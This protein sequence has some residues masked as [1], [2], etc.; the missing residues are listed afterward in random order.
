MANVLTRRLD[1]T[2]EI[3]PWGL[4]V[5]LLEL[6]S[7]LAS[8][9]WSIAVEGGDAIARGPALLVAPRRLVAPTEPLVLAAAVLR[10]TGRPLRVLG[11][12]DIAPIGPVLRRLGGAVDHPVEARGLLRAG[13]LVLA[14]HEMEIDAPIVD[15]RTSGWELGRRWRV[16]LTSR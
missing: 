1:G 12:P 9:R 13:H 16:T 3:D 2:F 6:L 7:P 5:D 15:V 4:D 11:I 8:I 14:R 10:A